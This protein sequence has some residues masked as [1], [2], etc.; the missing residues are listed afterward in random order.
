MQ[1]IERIP[2]SE[3]VSDVITSTLLAALRNA[4]DLDWN[5]IHGIA[6]WQ[7]VREN[8]LRLAAQTGASPAVVELFA[9]LHDIKR[10][11]DGRDPDHGRRAADWARHAPNKV[12]RLDDKD[13]EL[14]LYACEH[15][16]EGLTLADVTVQTC[17]DADRLDLGRVGIIPTPPRLCTAA[18]RDADVIAWAIRRSQNWQT[19]GR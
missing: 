17:W 4:Y 15:H 14:L 18:A 3:I 12:F 6:H 19:V 5:G 10:R 7:R 8:G 1:S 13:F 2:E 11:N 16:T 9:F